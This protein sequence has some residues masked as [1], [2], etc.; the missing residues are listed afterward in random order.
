MANA[1]VEGVKEGRW[2]TQGSKTAL[3][4][5]ELQKSVPDARVIYMTATA[6]TEVKHM[7]FADRLGLWGPGTAFP[8][9]AVGEF[10]CRFGRA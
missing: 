10:V 8:T 1:K 7:V 3:A 5:L 6:A 2:G 9:E 4:G